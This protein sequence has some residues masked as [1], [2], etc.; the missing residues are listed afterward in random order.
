MTESS[1]DKN[2]RKRK[3]YYKTI[4]ELQNMAFM[5]DAS[6][7]YNH[8][9][10]STTTIIEDNIYLITSDIDGIGFLTVDVQH[11]KREYYLM[12]KEELCLVLYIMNE[13]C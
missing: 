2:I 8:Y 7:I 1:K 4:A 5:N 10:E 9:K 13:L 3:N 12:M 6:K 11:L